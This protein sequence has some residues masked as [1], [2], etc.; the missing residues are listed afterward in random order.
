MGCPVAIQEQ[1]RNAVKDGTV[2]GCQ[3]LLENNGGHMRSVMVVLCT[4]A[5][6]F[7]AFSDAGADFNCFE[8]YGGERRCAC[9]GKDDCSQ[10]K[11]SHSC[12]SEPKCDTGLGAIVCSCEAAKDSKAGP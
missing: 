12:K 6:S 8:S 11:I 5:G 4:L 3:T 7:L 2:V 1:N 9:A 10:M